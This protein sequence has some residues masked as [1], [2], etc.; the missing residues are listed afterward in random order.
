MATGLIIKNGSPL[1]GSPIVYQVVAE[2]VQGQCAFHRVKLTVSAAL[3]EGADAGSS[4][5][6]STPAGNGETLLFD[7]SSALRAV[8]D[9]YQYSPIPPESYPY[10]TYSLSACDE[11]MLEGEV[12]DNVGPVSTQGGRVIMGAY[13]DYERMMSGGSKLA[14]HFSRKPHTLPEIVMVGE[15][16][17][18]PQSFADDASEATIVSGPTSLVVNIAAEG[19]QT[20]NGRQVYALPAGQ[21]DRY[22][23]RFVNGLGCLESISL[24]SLRVV[25]MNCS[26]ETYI[27]AVQESFGSFS[28][29]SV[30]K[31][32]DY[33]TW[34]M[35]SPPLDEAWHSW[36]LHEFLM[37]PNVWIDIEGHW[38]PC[39]VLPEETIEGVNR[40]D[41]N[42]L[43]AS[44]SVRLDMNGS[45]LSAIAV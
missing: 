19:M 9:R 16:M 32:S 1:I 4:I 35:S 21:S 45:P 37:S 28:R 2:S 3:S 33:E 17:V 42:L 12:H 10:L 30:S 27:R 29:S 36:F 11:Y 23:F 44:F 25:E 14:R 22:Q 38:V 5:T 15:T 24:S 39:Q 8:A 34:R 43:T 20:I 41:A 13:S 26:V 7:I 40:V 18:C 31:N 6:L